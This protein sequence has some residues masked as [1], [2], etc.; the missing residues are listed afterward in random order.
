MVLLC[1]A[2]SL[3]PLG[4]PWKISLLE[5]AGEGGAAL[6][7]IFDSV[8]DAMISP[9]QFSL[10]EKLRPWGGSERLVTCVGF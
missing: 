1:C 3:K 7:S 6:G 4:S 5:R 10:R 9:E 2:R 8:S